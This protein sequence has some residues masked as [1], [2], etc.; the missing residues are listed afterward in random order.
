METFTAIYRRNHWGFG[1]G[2]G[3][4][5]GA[6]RPYRELIEGFNRTRGVRTVV[7]FGCGDWQFSRLIDWQCDYLGVDIVPDVIEQNRARFDARNVRFEVCND[8]AALPSADLLLVKDVLQHWDTASITDFVRNTL[9][10]FRYALIT[11][12]AKPKSRLNR[13]IKT[14]KFRPLD[15]RRPP[16]NVQAECLLTFAGPRAFSWRTLKFFPAWE[17]NVLLVTH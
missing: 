17:K 16:F 9:P 2:H 3:S 11:N 4:L 8:A 10:R 15:L 6:T 7:D 5:V 1:S 14:G 13:E 12:C